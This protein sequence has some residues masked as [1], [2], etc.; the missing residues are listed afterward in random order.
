MT[1][2]E[3]ALWDAARKLMTA[4]IASPTKIGSD[5]DVCAAM[6]ALI[7][8]RARIRLEPLDGYSP[9]QMCDRLI[10]YWTDQRSKLLAGESGAIPRR[11]TAT[12]VDST[13]AR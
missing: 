9:V 8:T 3:Q 6:D 13:K 1:E 12:K 11:H 5:K 10:D 2:R 7:L 4:V